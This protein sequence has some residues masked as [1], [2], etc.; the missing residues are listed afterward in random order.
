M[1][2]SMQKI[3]LVGTTFQKEDCRRYEENEENVWKAGYVGTE[4]QT[5]KGI[6]KGRGEREEIAE[7]LQE[8]G[9]N[10]CLIGRNTLYSWFPLW[11]LLCMLFICELLH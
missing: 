3:G 2:I 10:E 6:P 1:L 9:A 4:R 11:T 5:Q 7:R 8:E